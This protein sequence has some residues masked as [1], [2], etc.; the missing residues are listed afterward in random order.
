MMSNEE[1]ME[2][3]YKTSDICKMFDIS[4]DNLRYYERLQLLDTQR[5]KSRY[6]YFNFQELYQLNLL[7]NLKNIG[8]PI[9]E[10]KD[11]LSHQTT[12]Y[13]LAILQ[14]E[15]QLLEERI[16]QLTAIKKRIQRRLEVLQQLPDL[17]LNQITVSSLP[18]RSYIPIPYEDEQ[19]RLMKQ[20]K[21]K[22]QQQN[23]LTSLQLYP[24]G[25][26]LNMDDLSN[27]KRD[28][29][30]ALMDE[31]IPTESMLP[32]GIYISMYYYYTQFNIHEIIELL[33]MYC[34][35]HHYHMESTIVEFPIISSFD[36]NVPEE[37]ITFIQAKVKSEN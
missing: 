20:E 37:H 21:D 33:L 11:Y 3:Y 35:K 2:K 32:E 18:Q 10:M 17:T 7:Y 4:V 26:L 13:T 31:T 36:T 29:M 15:N 19:Q 8:I 1:S 22:E 27:I 14:K 28:C 23:V 30:I 24:I 5:S 16:Q 34:L 12:S 9:P 25:F 6:R